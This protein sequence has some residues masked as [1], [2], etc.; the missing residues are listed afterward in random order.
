MVEAK[1][2]LGNNLERQ[3]A[4]KEQVILA[5]VRN[6]GEL[7]R[8]LDARERIIEVYEAQLAKIEQPRAPTG[9]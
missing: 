8:E 2:V 7:R 6:L 9:G 1:M 5:Q 3:L 4:E